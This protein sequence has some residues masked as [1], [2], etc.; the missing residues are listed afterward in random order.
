MLDSRPDLGPAMIR[1]GGPF[2]QLP[3]G[4]ALGLDVAAVASLFQFG[5]LLRGAVGRIRPDISADV[6]LI[7]QGIEDLAVVNG[8]IGDLEVADQFVLLVDADVVL[9]P[10]VGLAVLLRPTGIVSDRDEGAVL[11]CMWQVPRRSWRQNTPAGTQE[12]HESR[13]G[14]P[15]GNQ[16]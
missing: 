14:R 5:L 9:V 7:E 15:Q 16:A 12:A 6:G 4:R 3:L 13:Q 1:L 10:E 8:C 11:S 2:G